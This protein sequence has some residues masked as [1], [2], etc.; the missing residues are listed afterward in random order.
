LLEKLCGL[1]EQ[2]DGDSDDEYEDDGDEEKGNDAN[3]DEAGTGQNEVDL[4]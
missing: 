3:V 2:A 1:G 4:D